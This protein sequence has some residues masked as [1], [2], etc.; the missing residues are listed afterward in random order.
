VGGEFDFEARD[1]VL[2]ER[3]YEET[4]MRMEELRVRGVE[5][6]VQHMQGRV[7][8]FKGSGDG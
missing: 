1:P 3:E 8:G 5:R 7:Q 6:Q 2:V 4:N